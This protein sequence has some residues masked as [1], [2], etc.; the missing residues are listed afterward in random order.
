[1]SARPL[2]TASRGLALMLGGTALLTV[3]DALVKHLLGGGTPLMELL[4]IRSVLV[5][6]A[7][8]TAFALRG[9][10]RR[11]AVIDRPGQLVRAAIGVAAPILFFSGLDRL[12]LTEA[13]VIAY[14]S[15][16]ST[17]ALSAWLLGERIGPLRWGGVVVGYAGVLVAIAPGR[18][19]STLGH[20]L[21]LLSGIAIS[22]FYVSGKRLTRSESAESLVFVYNLALGLV[23][24]LW[25][26]FVWRTPEAADAAFIALFALVALS[27]QWCVTRA[28]AIADASLL[29]PIEYTALVW[30]VLIDVAVWQIVPDARVIAGATII[31]GSC[32]FVAWRERRVRGAAPAAPRERGDLG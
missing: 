23:C 28:Y 25:M 10:S 9:E 32:L 5:C 19:E 13:T 16:F 2:D 15:T 14:A 1:M 4:F 7:L 31:V 6:L 20:L 22:A 3:M 27:G 11:L 21:V 12:S 17:V 30:V 26:P 18:G 24:A 29:A 8:W